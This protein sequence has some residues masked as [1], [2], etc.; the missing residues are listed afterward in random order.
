LLVDAAQT[1]GACPIDVQSPIID[2]LAFTGHKGL[3]G[4]QGTGGLYVREG[5]PLRPLKLGG[6]GRQSDLEEQPDMFPDHLES[7]TRN[8]VGIAGLG[9]AVEYVLSEGIDR[10]RAHERA[11]LSRFV[12]AVK[13]LAGVT[14]YGP[15]DP[16]RQLPVVSATFDSALPEGLRMSFGGCGGRAVPAAF[17]SIHP[18][19]AGTILQESY[20]I[21]VRVGLHCAPLAHKALGTFPDGTVRF[22]M[23]YCT[24]PHE[25]DVAVEAVKR[26]AD[27]AR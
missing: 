19:E 8:G 23:S 4:P 13:A 1:A 20:D 17:E 2:Y 5:R 14:L 10:I 9:A 25:V 7:G 12:G 15:L 3:Y 22:S 6:T 26:L 16:E 18:Q 11:M 24:T 21:A 27:R